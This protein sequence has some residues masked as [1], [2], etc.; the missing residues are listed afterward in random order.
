MKRLKFP[1][2]RLIHV[3]SYI[4]YVFV[5]VHSL[6][7]GTDMNLLASTSAL[8]LFVN[9]LFILL[10]FANTAGVVLILATRKKVV[11]P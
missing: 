1:R 3:S 2:W 4:L 8:E 11:K 10:A 6:L 9:F 5:I 7:L